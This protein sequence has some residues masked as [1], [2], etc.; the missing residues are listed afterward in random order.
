[1]TCEKLQHERD[2][3]IQLGEEH[4]RL[5]NKNKQLESNLLKSNEKLQQL[6][7]QLID[8]GNESDQKSILVNQLQ[9]KL[10][11]ADENG[12]KATERLNQQALNHKKELDGYVFKLDSKETQVNSLEKEVRQLQMESVRLKE[13]Q[14]K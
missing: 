5:K 7:R 12:F 6:D 11:E 2:K 3:F 13:Q 10:K 8:L 4:E 9:L 1:M 14:D